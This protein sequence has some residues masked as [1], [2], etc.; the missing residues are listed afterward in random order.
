MAIHEDGNFDVIDE[1][2][3]NKKLNI[4]KKKSCIRIVYLKNEYMKLKIFY[5]YYRSYF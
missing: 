1:A 5:E 3:K 2:T 4:G